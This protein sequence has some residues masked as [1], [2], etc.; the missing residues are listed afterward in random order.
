MFGW[1]SDIAGYRLMYVVAGF[2]ILVSTLVFSF[3]SPV[4]PISKANELIDAR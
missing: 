2:L 1:I 4:I 3:K